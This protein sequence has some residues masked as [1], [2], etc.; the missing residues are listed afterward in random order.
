MKRMFSLTRRYIFKQELI[1]NNPYFLG[2][3]CLEYHV[4]R[5][6]P[7]QKQRNPLTCVHPTPTWRP[8]SRNFR[9]AKEI[10]ININYLVHFKLVVL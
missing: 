7:L 6:E 4:L 10:E 5:L 9:Y 1:R 8:H 2:L 3:C